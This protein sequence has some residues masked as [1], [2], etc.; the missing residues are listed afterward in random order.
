ML[1]DEAVDG[2]LEIDEGVEDAVFEPPPCELGEE[3]FDGVLPRARCRRE[4]EGPTG[5]LGQPRPDYFVLVGRAVV[6]DHMVGVTGR[7][8]SFE[9]IQEPGELRNPPMDPFFS[10]PSTRLMRRS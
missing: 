2:G 6:E 10:G 5:M 8:V 4:V 9:R 7:N 1:L 3:A